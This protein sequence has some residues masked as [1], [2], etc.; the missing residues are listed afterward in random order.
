MSKTSEHLR[1]RDQSHGP[2]EVITVNE[3]FEQHP[4]KY[5]GFSILAAKTLLLALT[6]RR[7]ARRLHVMGNTMAR[8]GNYYW[9]KVVKK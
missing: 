5:K 1:R 8:Q 6:D 9:K 7:C 2:K 3:L 4:E